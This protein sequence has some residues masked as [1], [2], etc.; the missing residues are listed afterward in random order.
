MKRSATSSTGLPLPPSQC[1]QRDEGGQKARGN[2]RSPIFALLP[3]ARFRGTAPKRTPIPTRQPRPATPKRKAAAASTPLDSRRTSPRAAVAARLARASRGAIGYRFSCLSLGAR[4]RA[5]PTQPGRSPGLDFATCP[6]LVGEPGGN[7]A[8]LG[9]REEARRPPCKGSRG[10]GGCGSRAPA[11][12]SPG[13]AH[14]PTPATQ[15]AHSSSCRGPL[16]SKALCTP[17]P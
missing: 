16:A 13:V 6:T 4:G 3:L 2:A 12:K 14:P 17:E 10:E 15:V 5:R 9:E 1:R 11:N 7:Q 8:Q